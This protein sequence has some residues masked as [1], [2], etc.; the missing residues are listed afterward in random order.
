MHP[1][2]L[3]HLVHGVARPVHR[4]AHQVQFPVVTARTAAR[5]SRSLPVANRSLVKSA[6]G[7]ERDSTRV[8]AVFS[9]SLVPSKTSTGCRNIGM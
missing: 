6:R 4:E 5:L 8:W 3:E 2:T 9:V 1:R 7:S